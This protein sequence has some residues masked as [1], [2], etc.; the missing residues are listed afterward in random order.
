MFNLVK[1][2]SG[3]KPANLFT[4]SQSNLILHNTAKIY[5]MKGN[6]PIRLMYE[7]MKNSITYFSLVASVYE[8]TSYLTLKDANSIHRLKR[9]HDSHFL[10]QKY[11]ILYIITYISAFNLT[12][13]NSIFHIFHYPLQQFFLYSANVD[14]FFYRYKLLGLL[15][16]LTKC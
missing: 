1:F 9:N 6:F 13:K 8:I 16:L 11:F 3:Y 2:N 12:H 7:V 4:D 5:Y 14:L 10:F 15:F